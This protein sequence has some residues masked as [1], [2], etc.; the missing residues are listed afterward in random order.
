MIKLGKNSLKILKC[1]HLV[2]AA[3]WL[4]GAFSLSVLNINNAAAASE[5]MLYG[6]NIA[7]HLVDMWV[8]VTAGAMGCLFTG[9][10]YSLSSGWGFIRHK[11]VVVKWLLTVTAILSG[12][13]FLGVWERSMLDLSR[14][15]GPEALSDQAYLAIKAKHLTVRDANRN[16]LNRCVTTC[17]P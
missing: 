6:L 10:L 17:L 1:F 16:R 7:S 8:V 12:T 4:G 2:T 13:F 9:L 11:W 3:C 5:G 15:L 14:D